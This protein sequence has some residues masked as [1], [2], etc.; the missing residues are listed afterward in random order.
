MLISFSLVIELSPDPN[1]N[2]GI[3]SKQAAIQKERE[4]TVLTAIY[5]EDQIPDSPDE[6]EN[7]ST[8]DNNNNNNIGYDDLKVP[9]IPLDEVVRFFV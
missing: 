6:P 7:E 8:I 3:D 2:R 4:K 5:F 9:I 1:L